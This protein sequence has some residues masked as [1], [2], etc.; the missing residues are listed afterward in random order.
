MLVLAMVTL[1]RGLAVCE[2]ISEEGLLALPVLA[3]SL[4]ASF[5]ANLLLDGGL[6][7]SGVSAFNAAGLGA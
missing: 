4:F 2:G 5:S 6:E 3:V 7:A 1:A